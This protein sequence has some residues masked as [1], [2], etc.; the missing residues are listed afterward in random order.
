[1]FLSR[2][3][4]QRTRS[5]LDQRTKETHH[6]GRDDIELTRAVQGDQPRMPYLRFENDL[7]RRSIHRSEQPDNR[8]KEIVIPIGGTSSESPCSRAIIPR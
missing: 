7:Q 5:D 8:R 1:M 2:Y 4:K 6:S 3:H